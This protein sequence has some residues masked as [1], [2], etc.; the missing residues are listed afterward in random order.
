MTYKRP[1][2][3]YKV[4]Q[5]KKMI[6]ELQKAKEKPKINIREKDRIRQQI[7]ANCNHYYFLHLSNFRG[8]CDAC[9]D[10]TIPL[11]KKCIGFK[12]IE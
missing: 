7:C 9:D 5:A 6:E 10:P 8:E 3:Q 4:S 12:L 2:D 11:E 1:E